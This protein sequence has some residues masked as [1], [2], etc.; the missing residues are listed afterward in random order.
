MFL[1]K[2]LSPLQ[3]VELVPGAI[4]DL[5]LVYPCLAA[6]LRAF[7]AFMDF[8][9]EGGIPNFMDGIPDFMDNLLYI[10]MWYIEK[11]TDRILG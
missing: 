6:N 2:L 9:F 11:Y 4:R 10:L 5:Q 3:R 8:R 7:R 1:E